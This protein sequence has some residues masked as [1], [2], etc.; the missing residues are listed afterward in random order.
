MPRIFLWAKRR[1]LQA[2]KGGGA[3]TGRRGGGGWMAHIIGLREFRRSKKA[4]HVF[5]RGAPASAAIQGLEYGDETF[6]A[7]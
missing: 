1:R 6:L 3:G 2:S 7:E 4:T 5:C